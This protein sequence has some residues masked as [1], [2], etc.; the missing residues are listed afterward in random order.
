MPNIRE[1]SDECPFLGE[2]CSHSDIKTS[3]YTKMQLVCIPCL[4]GKILQALKEAEF[5]IEEFIEPNP[6]TSDDTERILNPSH[7]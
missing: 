1:E 3:L 5:E 6:E 4:L 2:K 7:G